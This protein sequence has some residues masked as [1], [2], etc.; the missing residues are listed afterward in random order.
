LNF[1]I[2]TPAYNSE[3]Y[4]RETIES[5]ITQKG[6]FH[7]EYFVLD[8][9]SSDRTAVIVR[10]YQELLATGKLHVSCRGIQIK[11]ISERDSGMYDAIKKGLSQAHGDVYAW[12]NSDDVYLPGAFDIIQKTLEKYPEISWLKG[13]TS[14]MNEYS[15][16]YAA[17]ECCLYRQDWIKAGLYGTALYF[18]QQ[19]SVFWRADLWKKSGGVD[20]KFSMAGDYF[21]WKSFAEF[22]PLYSLRAYLSCFRK[23]THQ[24]SSNMQSYWKEIE[25]TCTPDQR[26]ASKV[27]RYF[28]R[29]EYLP[30]VFQP[31]F[32]N[33]LFGQHK[34]YL[35]I[36]ENAAFPRLE[37]GNYHMMKALT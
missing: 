34:H 5:V 17:G 29:I 2:V 1:S 28:G 14:Y 31:F 25:E 9:H 10:E 36:L 19:D 26:L 30:W 22:T 24:K 12:I 21:L 8:N 23:R 37:V 6:D 27:K 20:N 16:I 4:I 32:Y 13:I 18:I 7:I 3:K 15:T 35:V 11:L 33:C